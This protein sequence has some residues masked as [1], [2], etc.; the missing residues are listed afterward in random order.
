MKTRDKQA[1]T[2]NE[3]V[4]TQLDRIDRTLKQLDDKIDTMIESVNDALTRLDET[5]LILEADRRAD[6][7]GSP[8]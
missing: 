7:F 1:E 2:A 3:S 5:I 4:D 6:W 8:E